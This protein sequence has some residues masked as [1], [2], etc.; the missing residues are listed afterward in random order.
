[1]ANDEMQSY[2]RDESMPGVSQQLKVAV[3]IPCYNEGKAIRQVVEDFR[4]ALPS[5]RIYVY[6][7]NSQDDTVA[8]AREAGAVVRRE[9]LQGKGNV[10][11]RMF[12]D[13][14]ADVYL[15]CD[16]DATYDALAAGKLV[17]ALQ[18]EQL[19]MV[20]GRRVATAS[21]A[22][23]RR[24]HRLGNWLLTGVLG[25]IF[26]H[27]FTDVLSGYRGFSRRFVKS[28]PALSSG[29]D[30]EVELTIHALELGL[31]TAEV[32]TQYGERPEGSESKLHTYSDGLRI[33]VRIINLFRMEKPLPFFS[34]V[35]GLLAIVSLGLAYPLLMTFLET[36]LVPRLPTAIL[37]ASLMI[38]S[39]LSLI[40]GLILDTVTRGRREMRRLHYLSIPLERG[41]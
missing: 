13:V 40:S 30:I 18:A 21:V 6:D 22:A 7:N 2:T 14:E 33:L 34:I 19:D 3:L 23:Y 17:E 24:G 4:R 11:R 39:F 27:R 25:L 26:G 41:E 1:V 36:G 38:L 15:L 12:S 5:A 32:D 35:A 31:P 16:G 28:F 8:V 9:G 20:V 10:V 37:S 29:F